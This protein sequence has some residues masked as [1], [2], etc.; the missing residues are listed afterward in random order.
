MAAVIFVIVSLIV[1]VAGLVICFRKYNL[2]EDETHI[3]KMKKQ[4]EGG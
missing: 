4:R 2:L 1:V 3:D